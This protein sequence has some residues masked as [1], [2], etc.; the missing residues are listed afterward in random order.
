MLGVCLL[1]HAEEKKEV[2]AWVAKNVAPSA[3]IQLTL[4]TRNVPVVHLAAYRIDP[5]SWLSKDHKETDEPQISGNPIKQWDVTVARP[6]DVRRA[7]KDQYYSRQV[8][9]P[10]LN[11]GVYAVSASGGGKRRIVVANVTHLAVIAKQSPSK[12][13]VWV[14]D[15]VTEKIVPGA[16]VTA[17]DKGQ[18]IGSWTTGKDGVVLTKMRPGSSNLVVSRAGDWAGVPSHGEPPRRAFRPHVQ[19]DRPI[20]RPG[21]DVSFKVILRR[22]AG[23]EYDVLGNREVTAELR[24]PKNTPLDVLHLT[25]NAMGS[26]A[27]KFSLPEEGATGA[28][29]IVFQSGKD[30]AYHTFTVAAYRKPEFKI[31]TTAL[32]KR[33]L[34]GQ[35]LQFK[36]DAQYYFGAPVG[37]A[38]V[39]YIVRRTTLGYSWS[40]PSEDAFYGG[41]G[42]LYARDT[43]GET[44]PVADDVVHT[45]ENGI[46][47]VKIASD[48]AAP[49]SSYTIDCTV[50]DNSRRQVS[51]GASVPVYAANIRIGLSSSLLYVPLGRL[52]PLQIR[53]SDLDGKPASAQLALVL[54]HMVWNEKLGKEE[55][56]NL[57]S[58]SVAVGNMGKALAS[59]PAKAEG[60]LY[61]E[62]KGP[63]GTGRTATAVFSIYVAGDKPVSRNTNQP[64]V[65]IRLDKKSY[66]PGDM[67]NVYVSSNRP[68][69]PVLTVLEGEDIWGYRVALPN[70]NWSVPV[71]KAFAPNAY[72]ASSQWVKGELVE[73]TAIM[74]IPD[75]TRNLMVRVTADKK[76]YEPGDKA[77]YTIRTSD[78]NGKPVSAEIALSVVD[79]AIYALSADNT[80]DLFT[81]YWGPRENQ[82]QTQASAPEELSGGAYQR[83]S[84]VA[85]VRQR[86]EDTAYWNA[87]VATDASGEGRVSFEMPGNLTTWRSTARGI[88]MDTKVGMDRASVMAT[89]A[90]TLLL[91]APR[92]MVQGDHLTLIGTV[93]NRTAQR[94]KFH[95][96]VSPSGVQVPGARD[97]DIEV[98]GNSAATVLFD[99]DA[100]E[101]H[102]SPAQLT[103]EVYATDVSESE[104]VHF[105]DALQVKVPVLAN[106]VTE[107][108]LLGGTIDNQAN[109][110]INLPDDKIDPATTATLTVWAGVGPVIEQY[111]ASVLSSYRYGPMVAAD[112]LLVASARKMPASAKAVREAIAMLSKTESSAGWGYWEGAPAHP[113]VT[114]RVLDAL[115]AAQAANLNVPETLLASARFAAEF[116]YKQTNLWEY[117][118]V[119]ASSLAPADP[120]KALPLLQDV[121]KRGINMSP[122]ARLRLALG[123]EPKDKTTAGHI[124][125]EIV[126]LANVS[127]GSAYVP[128]GEGVGWNASELQTAALLLQ[129][130]I[131]TGVAGNMRHGLTQWILNPEPQQWASD[132]DR[133]DIVRALV[134]AQS[135]TPF[136]KD[137]GAVNVSIAGA[138]VPVVKST[139][140]ESVT[141]KIPASMLK[142]GHESLAISRSGA[143]QA[144]YKIEGSY[145]RPSGEEHAEGVRVVRRF[146]VKNSAGIWEELQR[147]LVA[148]EP[149]RVTV[150]IWGS[151]RPEAIRLTEPIPAGFEY[152]DEESSGYTRS[153]VRDS[154][155]I[156]YVVTEGAPV[157]VRYY[158]RAESDGKFS[159]LPATA[160]LIRK[161]SVRGRS[162]KVVLEVRKR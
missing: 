43:Y 54:Y 109:V 99:L 79:E 107:R 88:T 103:A 16:S 29:S 114:A 155:V 50:T 73:G 93:N 152:V 37:N 78:S 106:G 74:A 48:A 57:T 86:F 51:G 82:V 60:D 52:I 77:T 156:H 104:R 22:E 87:F 49:D 157:F 121:L 65:A 137:L 84:T 68:K 20:Y 42:N 97:L 126:G 41:D 130:S 67:S 32:A 64:E 147:P 62:A 7:Q 71:Q 122:Y 151:G 13:L 111:S 85:P 17:Y 47:I 138:N 139:V 146:E 58:T 123:L 110:A 75:R 131:K 105:A 117:K 112:Q 39:R 59:L 9:L 27:G 53:V 70:S 128:V 35:E 6:E 30:E 26:A 148:N 133:S 91:A 31:A 28:Y 134:E 19:T 38:E 36:V 92:Q 135:V 80:A 61:I 160:E 14:T 8:N 63:D 2:N 23:S 108:F 15:A 5:V 25:T 24:D 98:D 132:E 33:Y 124:V 83:V 149:I 116:Q 162:D 12:L 3:K 143:G 120:D 129:A 142:S 81:S 90:V 154:A 11:P 44:T 10:L 18:R 153:D 159:A 145:V 158:V 161:P 72:V 115:E 100:N 113:L 140:S 21:Q 127:E 136:A 34:A 119:L 94:H 69:N 95:V 102:D 46:A 76:E 101:F 45:D 40:D 4:N 96:R 55:R 89:R 125:E 118:A 150:L 56:K 141:A 144:F 1:A 66:K